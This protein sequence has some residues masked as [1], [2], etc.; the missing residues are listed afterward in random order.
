MLKRL[1]D[2]SVV[3]VD[4]EFEDSKEATKQWLN[5]PDGQEFAAHYLT[6]S[7]VARLIAQIEF[8]NTDV[9]FASLSFAFTSLRDAGLLK[10]KAAEVAEQAAVPRTKTGAPMTESQKRWQEY[11]Q[12]SE[13]S[14]MQQVRDRTKT[15]PGFAS[16]VKKQYERQFAE[17][18]VADA[19][20][21]LDGSFSPTSTR[22]RL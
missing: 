22:G 4:T 11:R 2:G 12:F 5:T 13:Q 1:D 7:N 10:T 19:G 20:I 14:S 9:T 16:F 21:V 8:H 3:D 6:D 15:D 17:T 18:Q